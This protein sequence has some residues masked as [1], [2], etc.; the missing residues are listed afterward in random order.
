MRNIT[1]INSNISDLQKYKIV[2]GTANRGDTVNLG[3]KVIAVVAS[4]NT[5]DQWLV[6]Q[7][8]TYATFCDSI[9]VGVAGGTY[10]LQIE[11]TKIIF[12]QYGNMPT[13]HYKAYFNTSHVSINRPTDR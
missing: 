12:N 10:G 7:G 2:E 5:Y 1:T 4:S 6:G 9:V 13:V 8:V 11:G 3:K